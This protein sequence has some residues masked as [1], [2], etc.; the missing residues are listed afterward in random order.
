MIRNL[1]R[2]DIDEIRRLASVASV[3]GFQFLDRFVSEVQKDSVTLESS[4]EFFVGFIVRD[5]IVAIGGVTPDP[6]LNDSGIGR[7][8]H[9]YV[10]PDCRRRS[11]GRQL[12]RELEVRALRVYTT[13]RLRTDTPAAARFYETMGYDPVADPTATH[14]RANLPSAPEDRVSQ[15]YLTSG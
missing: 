12:I 13:L 4:R 1:V 5:E 3:E 9:L 11:V 2:S 6:Y 8:R 14:V 10:R 15:G 7:L